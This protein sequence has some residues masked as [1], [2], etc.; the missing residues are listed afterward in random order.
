MPKAA[1]PTEV[2]SV[3]R[4]SLAFSEAAVLMEIS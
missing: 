1:M 2:V 4:A 3:G